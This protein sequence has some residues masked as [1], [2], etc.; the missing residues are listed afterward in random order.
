[1]LS[2]ALFTSYNSTSI[3]VLMDFKFLSAYH[4]FE[5]APNKLR[6]ELAIVLSE[7]TAMEEAQITVFIE[8]S[9]VKEVSISEI[10]RL[11]VIRA[12]ELLGV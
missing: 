8:P 9:D 12:K 11:A 4:P 3:G 1:M 2:C 7:D 6:V 5:A 10:E